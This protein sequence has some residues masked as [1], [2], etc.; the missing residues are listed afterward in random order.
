MLRTSEQLIRAVLD[1]A[2]L[3]V[4]E[5]ETPGVPPEDQIRGAVKA[6][7]TKTHTWV[8]DSEGMWRHVPRYQHTKPT[9]AEADLLVL[10]IEECAEVQQR[11]TKALRFGLT[12]K[13]SPSTPS[14][15]DL[16]AAEIGD[17][18]GVI[19][20]IVEQKIVSSHIIDE[21]CF[22]KPFRAA[23]YSNE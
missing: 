13:R 22:S 16:L 4:A 7:Q 6:L 17:L 1:R 14:N 9:K 2:D 10:L 11:A 23:V 21:S 5:L 12:E 8:P 20:M 19:R 3:F 15:Q 18:Q